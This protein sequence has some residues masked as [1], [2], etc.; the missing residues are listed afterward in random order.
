[1]VF[2]RFVP[3]PEVITSV[4]LQPLVEPQN[5]AIEDFHTVGAVLPR[6]E[7]LRCMTDAVTARHE[8]H[9]HRRKPGYFSRVVYGAASS[10]PSRLKA[11]RPMRL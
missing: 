8:D 10:P 2:V 4:R 3:I 5:R 9:A 7:F 6:S 1:M 11:G